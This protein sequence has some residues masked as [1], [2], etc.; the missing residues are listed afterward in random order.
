[1]V[2][3]S[4]QGIMELQNT[5][6]N[7]ANNINDYVF[8]EYMLNQDVLWAKLIENS[9]QFVS[10]LLHLVNKASAGYLPMAPSSP[11]AG[12][13]YYYRSPCLCLIAQDIGCACK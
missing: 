6:N 8:M 2:L 4:S 7:H 1:M 12:N 5:V 11:S 13:V 10:M 9:S 3:D